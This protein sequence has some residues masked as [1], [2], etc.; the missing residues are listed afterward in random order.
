MLIIREIVTQHAEESA[1]LWLLRDSAI[2]EPHYKLSDLAELDDRVEAHIDE[3]RVAGDAGWEICRE[4]LALEETG[5]I[6]TAAVLAFGSGIEERIKFVLEAVGDDDELSRGVISALGWIP[7]E[8]IENHAFDFMKSES[9]ALRRIGLAAFAVHRKDPGQFLITALSDSD[10]FLKARALRAVG[11]LG[12]TDLFPVISVYLNEEDEN[13]RFFAAWSAA[14]L[15]NGSAVSVLR[16]IFESDGIHTEKA[17]S[18]ALRKM[19]LPDA[20]EWVRELSSEGSNHR[21]LAANGYGVIGDPVAIP[22]LIQMMEMPGLVRVIGESFSMI[23]GV[24]IAY[25]DLEGEWPEGFEAGPTEE[26]E[27]EDVEMDPDE[28]LPWPEPVLI[29]EWWHQNKNNFRTGTR[30]LCGKPITQEQCHHVLR[31]GYQRQ[32]AAPAIELAILNP[33][34]PLFEVRDPGFR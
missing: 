30:Y 2:Y 10:A 29:S 8:K 14:L 5:E 23:T 22:W 9:P 4:A 1:F 20:H 15:G 13:C 12:R 33:A 27:D 3:L 16:R 11:E 18:M 19:N 28:D 26:P 31:H 34:R 32:R 6:F 17:F 21:R 24:D 25:E 7:Y